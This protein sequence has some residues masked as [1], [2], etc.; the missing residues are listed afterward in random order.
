LTRKT[1]YYV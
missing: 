1:Y